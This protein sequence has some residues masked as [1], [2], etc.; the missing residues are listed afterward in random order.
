MDDQEGA[1]AA[2]W[3]ENETRPGQDGPGAQPSAEGAG[4]AAEQVPLP[5]E[6]GQTGESW[7]GL[8]GVVKELPAGPSRAGYWAVPC[9]WRTLCALGPR[10]WD[11]TAPGLPVPVQGAL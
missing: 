7:T 1:A 2:T 10:A 8:A 4:E 9:P 3:D 6:Q 11:Q 5:T